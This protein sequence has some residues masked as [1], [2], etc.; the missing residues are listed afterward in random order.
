MCYRP[1]M[2]GIILTI[3]FI[4]S[5]LTSFGQSM[6]F[7]NL[8]NSTWTSTADISDLTIKN[9]KQIPLSKLIYSKDSINK[10]VTIWTFKDSVL[11]IVNYDC[12]K[13][14]DSLVG[15]YKFEVL[16]DISI[17]Q[18]TLRDNLV[19]NYKVGIVSTGY[20]AVLLRTKEKKD[21]NKK[22]K[23]EH[24]TRVFASR[25]LTWEIGAL[26]YCC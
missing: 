6:F 16:Q 15:T 25:G 26:Y 7:N 23:H 10:D 5:T 20:Y 13:K 1:T 8:N 9:S 19:L 2:K 11:T 14:M 3:V 24:I 22:W 12:H 21:K 4:V 18:I 17:L